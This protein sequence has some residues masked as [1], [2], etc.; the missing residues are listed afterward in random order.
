MLTEEIIK[1]D[2]NLSG[3]TP[4]QIN[5][6]TTLSRNDEQTVINSRI[7]EIYGGIDKDLFEASGIE[8]LG[9]SEKT[10]DYA[11]RVVGTYKEKIE[12]YTGMESK[13]KE[14]ESEKE[15]LE[16]AIREGVADKSVIEN[17]SKAEAELQKTKSLF[18][19]MK[20][21]YEG[22]EKEW[23]NKIHHMSIENEL[24][25]GLSTIDFTKETTELT[26]RELIDLSIQKIKNI[27]SEYIDNGNGGKVLVFYD[28]NGARM[29]NPE[30]KLNPFTASELLFNELNKY[31]IISNGQPRG[32]GGTG[33]PNTNDHNRSTIDLGGAKNQIEAEEMASKQL[34]SM[35]LVRGSKD[36]DSKLQEAWKAFEVIKLPPR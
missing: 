24:R 23:N 12:G 5:S 22:Q 4:E 29:N 1:G 11:K 25:S 33:Q 7:G 15:K 20:E 13:L 10:Y 2:S 19:E 28:E 36:Y 32:G 6:I 21:K 30:N 18:V 31:G 26:K 17:L 3:L 14:L 35:G 16:K 34:S 27:K 8:K 9:S